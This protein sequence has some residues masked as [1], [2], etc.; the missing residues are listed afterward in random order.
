MA[1]QRLALS[2]TDT[3]TGFQ[4]IRHLDIVAGSSMR[5][6]NDI[7]DG[8]S[9][10]KQCFGGEVSTYSKLITETKN[11]AILEM[12]RQAISLGANAV[13]GI[14]FELVN[15]NKMSGVLASGTAVFL[16]PQPQ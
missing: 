5:A 13:V 15:E 1:S 10:W 12:T 7:S 9:S 4:I 3:V 6:R 8:C 11:Q 16:I 14:T 2:T